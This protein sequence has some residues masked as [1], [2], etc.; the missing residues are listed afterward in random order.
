MVNALTDRNDEAA[1]KKMHCTSPP[2]VT[3][4]STTYQFRCRKCI[5]CKITRKQEWT[6]RIMLENLTNEHSMFVTL[7]YDNDHLPEK[8]KY[9]GGNLV[10]K[11][12]QGFIKRLRDQSPEK[13]RYFGVGE[14]GS[15]SQRAHFHLIIY[16][17]R[18]QDADLIQKCWKFG[19]THVGD[20]TN[21]SAN[22]VAQYT[23]KKITGE[24]AADHY[25]GRTPEFQLA[26]K[27][28]ALG[29]E[30]AELIAEALCHEKRRDF[31]LDGVIRIAGKKYPLD[32]HMQH[33]VTHYMLE[34]GYKP[35]QIAAADRLT[36]PEKEINRKKA[37]IQTLQLMR[38]HIGKEKI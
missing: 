25:G 33:R 38:K 22:Y 20:L 32:K 29:D 6:A 34:N 16:N 28:P 37:E 9:S 15:Q 10:K 23:T 35:L 2:K 26:S 31:I 17:L 30:A 36:V 24:I 11:D 19:Y 5:S 14:Y 18:M 12:L 4:G 13:I 7:T 8:E 21:A 27:H 3:K 1:T